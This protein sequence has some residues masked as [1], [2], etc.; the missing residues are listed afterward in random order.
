[1]RNRLT[2][3]LS[4]LV[5]VSA[6]AAADGQAELESAFAAVE[7]RVIEWRRDL[8]ANPEL[9]NREFRTAEKVAAHLRGLGFDEVETG[10]AHTGVVGTLRGGKPGPVIALR[11]DM[12]G[13]PVLEQTGLPFASRARGEYMGREVPVM[14]A[15][16]HDTHV[17]MLMGAAEVLAR[18][19]ELLAGT[20]KFI[21]QPAEEGAPP[22]EEGGAELMVREGVLDG[23]D[24]PEAIL[25]LHVWPDDA[26]SLGYRSGS[27]M[28]AADGIEIKV[29]GRQT[30]GSSP[31]LG[32]DPIYVSGQIL[33][34]LQGIPGRHVDITR[35]PA[36][37]TIGSI[38]GGVRGN[39]IPDDVTMLGTVRTFDMEERERLLQ[40]L[41]ATVTGIAEANGASA[42][43]TV[44]GSTPV[45][46]NHPE[47]LQTMMPTLVR[48]AGEDRVL[49]RNL[50]TGA[51]DFSYYQEKIPGLFLMLG[52]GDPSVPREERPSNHSPF[53]TAQ[54]DAL[55]VGV[56]TLVGFALDYP[57]QR[58]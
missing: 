44:T 21:F 29:T 9:S 18:N 19:R 58:L 54:E 1:M 37:V 20:V 52:V 56:R 53:F 3:L 14:H 33:A 16:G 6:G 36:V 27:F 34:A 7:P 24:A 50:I 55:I 11:A 51:E 47:L 8:H 17:A 26:G 15:C 31:W 13:L 48:A 23:P 41:E 57:G 5:V 40:R 2:Q 49:E 45:T 12:D 38:Q 39:I 30:H 43:L 32:V 22:G 42:T 4:A 46:G 28:A 35:G 10:I 25:G